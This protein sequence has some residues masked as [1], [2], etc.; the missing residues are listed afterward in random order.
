MRTVLFITALLLSTVAC[1]DAPVPQTPIAQTKATI[2]SLENVLFTDSD[3]P[4]NPTA[5]LQLVRAYAKY[6]QLSAKDSTAISM[7]FKAAE[8]SMGIGQGNLAIKYYRM[9]NEDHAQF[10]KAPEALFLAG[11]CA[12]NLNNDTLQARWYYEKFMKQYPNHKLVEDAQFSIV[13][14]GKSDA[15]LIEMF[16]KNKPQ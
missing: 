1:K 8:V 13:N 4:V 5:G 7:L 14:M 6:Y 3:A 11:F 2:D 15:E 16:Q 9:V 10:H 12:E